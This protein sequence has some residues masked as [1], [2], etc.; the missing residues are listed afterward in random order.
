[1]VPLVL[2]FTFAVVGVRAQERLLT[3][4]KVVEV[5][6]DVGEVVLRGAT[7]FVG[8]EMKIRL[9]ST[10]IEHEHHA[11]GTADVHLDVDHGR[12]KEQKITLKIRDLK[13]SA[14]YT[15][16]IDGVPVT[17]FSTR[18][19][20]DADSPKHYP[21][22][23]CLRRLARQPGRR[24]HRSRVLRSRVGDRIT[25][26][27]YAR[28]F[29][30]TK[31]VAVLQNMVQI[32][33]ARVHRGIVIAPLFPRRDPKAEY[34]TWK[35]QRFEGS[36]VKPDIEFPWTPE[37]NDLSKDNQVESAVRILNGR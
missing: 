16:M 14:H 15:L 4:T 10:G 11:S 32:G 29:L 20:G 13:D 2:I 35:G 26:R 25:G 17:T 21:R 9:G 7:D 8:K 34:V 28:D 27:T 31:G 24:V 1:M 3:N 33:D 5:V 37:R 6:N 19:D 30:E 36:G 23:A 22:S 12:V 18:H